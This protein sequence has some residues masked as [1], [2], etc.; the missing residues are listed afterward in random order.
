MSKAADEKAEAVLDSLIS[1][2][3]FDYNAYQKGIQSILG[4]DTDSWTNVCSAQLY[5]ETP[6]VGSVKNIVQRFKVQTIAL[7]VS[8]NTEYGFSGTVVM[9]SWEVLKLLL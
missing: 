8:R 4:I 2:P 9:V 7:G 5:G 1:L 3:S 6:S